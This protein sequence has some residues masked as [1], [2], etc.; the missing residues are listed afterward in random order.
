MST[1]EDGGVWGVEAERLWLGVCPAEPWLSSA[2]VTAPRIS[3][4]AQCPQLAHEG[5][6]SS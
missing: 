4:M 1:E 3:L 6:V 2:H 5:D